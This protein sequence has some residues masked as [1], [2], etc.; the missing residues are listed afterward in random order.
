MRTPE[1]LVDKVTAPPPSVE[2]DDEEEGMPSWA[3][4]GFSEIAR[5][6]FCKP[7]IITNTH[8]KVTKMNLLT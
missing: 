5:N 7:S 4:L 1:W 6:A 2:E 3:S 8:F